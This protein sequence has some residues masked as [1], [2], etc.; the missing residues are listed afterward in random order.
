[1]VSGSRTRR[2]TSLHG[3]QKFENDPRMIVSAAS[4]AQRASDFIMGIEHKESL[5]ECQTSPE[6]MPLTWGAG[7][8]D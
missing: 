2:P 1:M 5:Q 6:G 7:S 3:Y 4:Q 8:W